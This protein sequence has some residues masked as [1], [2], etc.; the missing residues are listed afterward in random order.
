MA[1]PTMSDEK[2]RSLTRGQR[3]GYWAVLAAVAA[4]IAYLL[5]IYRQ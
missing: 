2:Y 3:M 1:G 4:L 5:F